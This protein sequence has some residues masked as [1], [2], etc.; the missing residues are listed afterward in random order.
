MKR[1]GKRKKALLKKEGKT[2]VL[3]EEGLAAALLLDA[4]VE[5]V[6]NKPVEEVGNKPVEEVENKPVEEVENKSSIF[7]EKLSDP[8][9]RK[10]AV[11]QA[12][13]RTGSLVMLVFQWP[14][15]I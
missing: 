2:W 9:E 7:L 13:G 11:L 1:Q 6:G 4:P 10:W 12:F 5:E 8:K 14:G 15:W 3:T